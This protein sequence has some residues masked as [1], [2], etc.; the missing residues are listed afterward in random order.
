MGPRILHARKHFTMAG[1]H[2]K[3]GSNQQKILDALKVKALSWI[4]LK[5]TTGIRLEFHS[6]LDGLKRRGRV[7]QTVTGKYRSD[8]TPVETEEELIKTIKKQ[9]AII[10]DLVDKGLS[11]RA[12]FETMKHTLN[13]ISAAWSAV[14]IHEPGKSKA[15]AYAKLE[16][17]LRRI[18][19]EQPT[20][21]PETV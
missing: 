13:L 20:T 14:A 3:I 16:A 6:A 21:S 9:S 19:T 4:D 18:T 17:L 12:E 1:T 8:Q 11:E 5:T 10:S 15:L 7:T 2:T